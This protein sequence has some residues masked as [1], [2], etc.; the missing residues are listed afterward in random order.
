[1]N[2]SKSILM[3]HILYVFFFTLL[4]SCE[5]P[6]E[7]T[8]EPAV[9]HY[10]I[11]KVSNPKNLP[12]MEMDALLT[13]YDDGN[14][15]A[16]SEQSNYTEGRAT[17]DD[18]AYTISMFDTLYS[19]EASREEEWLKL[20]N[21]DLELLL[22]ESD[23][24]HFEHLDLLSKGRNWWRVKPQQKETDKEVE[25]RVVSHLTYV[26]D[27]FQ[28]LEGSEARTF[29][30]QYLNL[31]LKLYGNGIAIPN[32]SK[33]DENW[34]AIFFDEENALH[35]YKTLTQAINSI[36]KYPKDSESHAKSFIK[37]IQMMIKY[38]ES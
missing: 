7:T 32:Y 13:F 33:L 38:I 34:K 19:F 15:T 23:K 17:F 8:D 6:T 27:Y 14:F 35:A 3:K 1:M 26:A 18:H 12:V 37:A 30:T 29:S 21:R 4:F 25:Q 9:H 36:E 2:N 11:I 5:N 31:P 24:L 10:R 16:V 20:K 28:M 22:T